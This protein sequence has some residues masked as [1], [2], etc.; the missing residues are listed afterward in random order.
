MESAERNDQK[1]N[2]VKWTT[3]NDAGVEEYGVE[4]SKDGSHFIILGLVKRSNSSIKNYNY[5]HIADPFE[6]MFYR[7][8]ANGIKAK[9][10]YSAIVKVKAGFDKDGIRIF[11]NPITNNCFTICFNNEKSGKYNVVV[12]NQSGEIFYQENVYVQISGA[13]KLISLTT[14]ITA[15]HYTVKVTDEKGTNSFNVVVLRG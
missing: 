13:F 2:L 8:R 4:Y 9:Q 1:S 6:N 7:I 12:R 14:S 10:L 5:V 3:A 11:P 15:G